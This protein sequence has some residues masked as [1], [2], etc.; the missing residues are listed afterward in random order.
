[1]VHHNHKSSLLSKRISI[2]VI[3]IIAIFL[4]IYFLASNRLSIQNQAAVS[5]SDLR[6][7][8]QSVQDKIID[9]KNN[10]SSYN[11]NRLIPDAKK[12][13]DLLLNELQNNPQTFL[14]HI[15]PKDQRDNLPPTLVK[16]G[17]FEGDIQAEGTFS[18]IHGDNFEKQTSIEQTTFTPKNIGTKGIKQEIYRVYFTSQVITPPI[19]AGNIT[20]I[21]LDNNLLS[22]SIKPDNTIS[23]PN[24]L[25]KTTGEMKTAVI[26]FNFQD[27]TS[28]P[29]SKEDVYYS[30][31]SPFNPKSVANYYKEVSY[32][33][34]TITGDKNDIF[35]WYKI[36]HSKEEVDSFSSCNYL[37]WLDSAIH[38][39]LLDMKNKGDTDNYDEIVII[40]PIN[41]CSF[42][43]IAN[44]YDNNLEKTVY[45][46]GTILSSSI[47]HEIGHSLGLNHAAA[48]ICGSYAVLNDDDCQIF[49]TGDLFDVMGYNG[50][51]GHF[52][53]IYKQILGWI[54]T[55]PDIT[56]DGQ[57]K[58]YQIETHPQVWK[59]KKPSEQVEYFIE[60]RKPIGFDKS[61]YFF[62]ESGDPK[63]GATFV[64]FKRK[65]NGFDYSVLLDP[66][67]K[68]ETLGVKFY[69]AFLTDGQTF[70]DPIHKIAITQ[71]NHTDEYANI[72]VKFDTP[73]PM[74]T[75]VPSTL[76]ITPLPSLTPYPTGVYLGQI[77]VYVTQNLNNLPS[78]VSLAVEIILKESNT[79][80]SIKYIHNPVKGKTYRIN[81]D[82]DANSRYYVNSY[83]VINES[84]IRSIPFNLE[85]TSCTGNSENLNID[86]RK[87]VC[88]V[89]PYG[90]VGLSLT[91][92]SSLTLSPNPSV[93]P[94]SS[95]CTFEDDFKV[96]YFPDG[97]CGVVSYCNNGNWEAM[98]IDPNFCKPDET[99]CVK[100]GYHHDTQR[101]CSGNEDSNGVCE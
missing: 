51:S 26:L 99:S 41:K 11:Y 34:L 57:Y 55:V 49:F 86:S 64:R 21:T 1:M 31:Y 85:E 42:N 53:G 6:V 22:Q 94:P 9:Y 50:F 65:I 66:N 27:D 20:G 82:V 38:S 3:I 59:I 90:V 68:N 81:F 76:S 29:F 13:H 88:V 87:K 61:I 33:K 54:P 98:V 12:R 47:I 7:L 62:Y 69:N 48:L 19:F 46:N 97:Y 8:T 16:T 80:V 10:P 45:L 72:E 78:D 73:D 60:Y 4:L 37:V 84:Q 5:P 93:Y 83:L 17:L 89:R 28:Q 63:F 74:Y 30:I 44:T 52:N 36:P 92:P 25:A 14:T 40:S 39:A 77:E 67:S 75:P 96:R 35:G 43:G 15:L 56:N 79:P 18:T 71:F 100:S 58:I 95:S 23:V 32:G 101:C 91:S 24:L 70:Y 2:I